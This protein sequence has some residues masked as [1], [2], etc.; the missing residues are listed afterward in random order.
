MTQREQVKYHPDGVD[1]LATAIAM[2]D[3]DFETHHRLALKA[4]ELAAEYGEV[5]DIQAAYE[6][7]ADNWYTVCQMAEVMG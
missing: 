3:P 1:R 5:L 7:T 2:P 6:R 4:I